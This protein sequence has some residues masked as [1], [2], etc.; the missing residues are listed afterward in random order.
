MNM[1]DVQ[2]FAWRELQVYIHWV[3]HMEKVY[4]LKIYTD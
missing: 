2:D 3:Q 4:S 1:Q